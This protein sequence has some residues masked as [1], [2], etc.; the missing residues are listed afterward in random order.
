[1]YIPFQFMPLVL[2]CDLTTCEAIEA[3]V[4]AIDDA[5]MNEVCAPLLEWLLVSITY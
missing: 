4:P 5:G 1:M 2:G 3:L